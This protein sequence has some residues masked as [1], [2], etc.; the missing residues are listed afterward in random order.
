MI[1]LRFQFITGRWHATGWGNH[2]NEGVPDWPPSP[3]RICRALI[4]TWF[5]KRRHEES[6]T[7][8]RELIAKLASAAPAYVLPSAT[9]SHTRH[10]VPVN[11]GRKEERTKIFDTFVHV[12]QNES[13]LVFWPVELDGAHRELLAALLAV[14]NYFGRAESLV[15]AELLPDSNELPQPNA[16]PI[17][18]GGVIGADEEPIRLLAPATPKQ[19]AGWLSKQAAPERGGRRGHRRNAYTLPGSVFDAL[20]ADTGDLKNAGWSQPPGS[21]WIE[22]ARPAESFRIAPQREPAINDYRPK[23]ARFAVVSDVPPSITEALNLGERFHRALVSRC[24][25]PVFTGCDSLGKPLT[26]GHQHAFYLSECDPQRGTIKFLT[27]YAP[28]GFDEDARRALEQLRQTW[29]YKGHKLQVILL[30]TG[31]RN[32]FAGSNAEPGRSLPLA[33]AQEWISLTPFIPTRH[34]KARRTG[35]PKRDGDGLVIGSPLHDLRRLLREAGF[36]EPMK[37][38]FLPHLAIGYRCIHWLEFQHSRH[39]GHGRKAGERGYGFRITF[40]KRVDGPITLGYGAHFGLGL[41]VPA[42]MT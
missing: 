5:H 30:G 23:V 29:G 17:E 35:V 36:P 21:R 18:T 8:L 26:D 6:D 25:S 40:S 34:V 38:D 28:M 7:Q 37:I 39:H 14:L 16:R 3:W 22:Y 33:S 24:P 32:L 42:D 41:F 13:L 12:A 9:A 4:A 31:E 10:Y 1:G 20:L 11:V 27:L 2:V 15:E 19:Y